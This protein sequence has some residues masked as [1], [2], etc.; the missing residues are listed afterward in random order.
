M[1]GIDRASANEHLTPHEASRVFAV[2]LADIEGRVG[3]SVNLAWLGRQKLGLDATTKL[4]VQTADGVPLAAII[5]SRRAAPDLVAR[6]GAMAEQVR[7]LVGETLGSVIPVPVAAG[8]ANGLSYMILPY[9][10]ELSTQRIVRKLQWWRLRRPV[11]GW[12]QDAVATAALKLDPAEAGERYALELSHLRSQFFLDG[13]QQRVIDSYLA[14]LASGDWRPR[15]TFDHNDIWFGNVMLPRPNPLASLQSP[16][17]L[18][19]WGGANPCGY[20]IYDL[21]RAGVA[22]GLSDK[23]LARETGRHCRAL[24]SE[25][26]D[27]PGHL[28]ASLGR[29]HRHLEEFPEERYI[30]VFRR[31]WI[32]LNRSLQIPV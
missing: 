24:G 4:L 32:T 3:R 1:E 23:A 13:D 9:Y 29:L 25:V 10:R 31:C 5:C 11:L 12:L 20:G 6:A 18:I 22:F 26:Q 16:F 8:H 15:H 14:R 28:L 2:A 30:A 7:A 17:L 19:D 21:V 27:A